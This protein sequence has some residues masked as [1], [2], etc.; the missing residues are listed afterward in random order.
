MWLYKRARPNTGEHWAE[1]IASEVA[2][3]LKLPTHKVIIAE[4]E[5]AIG[6]TVKNFLKKEE[7]GIL[8]HGNELL[9]GAIEGYDKEK[10]QGQSDHHFD[11]VVKTI[12]HWFSRPQDRDFASSRLIGYFVFDA[13]VGNTDRHHENWGMILKGLGLSQEKTDE[14]ARLRLQLSIA[15]TFD[16]GSSLGRELL[17][18]RAQQLLQDPN[19]LRRY[20]RKARGGIFENSDEAH[21]MSPLALL[22]LI[23]I[24]YPAFF[25]PWQERVKGLP[26]AFAQPLLD[27]ISDSIMSPTSKQFTLAFL[28]ET[29]K[30]ISDIA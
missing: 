28:A 25:K 27:Q 9:A 19:Q 8:I 23:A 11:N 20:I 15:P 3:L 30:F 29:R 18:E 2:E 14:Q 16:H 21:G 6:C 22:E 26:P 1:K 13:L 12:E 5:G 4:S 17:E 7:N 10:W 24:T